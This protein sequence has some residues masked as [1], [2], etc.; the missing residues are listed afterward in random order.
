M[1]YLHPWRKRE[2][3]SI[4]LIGISNIVSEFYMIKHNMVGEVNWMSAVYVFCLRNK[5]YKYKF[6]SQISFSSSTKT[7]NLM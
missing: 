4:H 1:L 3:E 6:Q 2:T 5:E 7:C